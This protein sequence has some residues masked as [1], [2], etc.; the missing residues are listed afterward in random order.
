MKPTTSFELLMFALGLITLN[1]SILLH[2]PISV[3][4]SAT[5][6]LVW[7]F[8]VVLRICLV[9]GSIQKEQA[10][11]TTVIDALRDHLRL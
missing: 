7:L 5:S 10:E 3:A 9:C 11:N 6:L 4:I 8:S 1:G 2:Q